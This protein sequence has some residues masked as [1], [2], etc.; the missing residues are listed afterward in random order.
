MPGDK[1]K[2]NIYEV[3]VE[4]S[5]DVNTAMRSV[6]VKVTDS[7]EPGKVELS[8]QDALIGVELTATLMDSDGGVPN[9]GQ[10]MGQEWEWQKTTPGAD[11]SC[12]AVQADGTATWTKVEGSSAYTPEAGDRGDCLRAMVTYTDRTYDED[13]VATNNNDAAFMSF[14][15]TAVSD[16]TT[17]VRNNPMPTRRRSSRRVR[18][19]SVSW[20]RTRWR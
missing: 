14:M 8:S 6:T 16:S 9:L 3:T 18:A 20:K 17:A 5:D 13:N 15:N 19:P 2:G 7:D 10:I 4:A 12:A 11:Q 1:N